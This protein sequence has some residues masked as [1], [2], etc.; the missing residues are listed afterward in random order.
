MA[1]SKERLQQILAC[2][3]GVGDVTARAM[4]G[5]YLLYYRGRHFGGVFDGRVL[6]KN[7]DTARKLLPDVHEI[8]PYPG[9]KAM[10]EIENPDPA[11][12]LQLLE[13]IYPELPVKK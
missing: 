2:M 4:M 8:I 12:L 13:T 10:L 3:P 5:E 7:L 6:I 1:T 11:E 9:A